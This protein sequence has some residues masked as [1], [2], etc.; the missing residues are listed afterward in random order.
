[1]AC[2]RFFCRSNYTSMLLLSTHSGV[3]TSTLRCMLCM[4][5]NWLDYRLQSLRLCLMSKTVAVSLAS[6][7]KSWTWSCQEIQLLWKSIL[8]QELGTTWQR[9]LLQLRNSLQQ[10]ITQ[11][12]TCTKDHWQRHLAQKESLGCPLNQS[13][14]S[15]PSNFSTSINYGRVIR[16]FLSE[17]VIIA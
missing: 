7:F 8:W 6:S 9:K 10:L 11:N 12:F 5:I 15:R 3:V 17:K 1:M 2:S 16:I 14:T 4:L 13:R